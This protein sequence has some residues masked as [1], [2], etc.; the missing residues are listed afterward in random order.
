[1]STADHGRARL[2]PATALAAVVAVAFTLPGWVVLWRTFRAD[3]AVVDLVSD[4]LGPLWRT[5][6]LA[7]LVSATAAVIGTGL[8]WLLVRTDLPGR[9]L[10]RL[11][12]VLP[13]ALPSFIGAAAFIAGV[14][15]GGLL[16]DVLGWFGLTPPRRLRGL[17]ISWLV[18]TAFTYPYVLLPV[19]ARLLALRPS[20]E[21]SSRM[22][23]AGAVATFVRVTLPQL[24]SAILGGSLL[25]YLYCVSE[26]GAVQL[27]G[28]DTLTRVVFATRLV[29]RATSF[30]AASM[31]LVLAIGVVA[32][33]RAQR[34]ASGAD[35]R[36]GH[37]GALVRLGWASIPATIACAIVALVGLITPVASLAVWARRGL[38]DGRVDLGELVEPTVN[39]AT[40][41]IVTAVVAVLVVLP[42]AIT[43][44][45]ERSA[46]GTVSA[47]AVVV[48]F[49]CPVW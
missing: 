46:I 4:L 12:L 23:G 11:V 25:V 49:A 40:V 26:F 47:G 24:R 5:I 20:L 39:T 10:W 36:A 41:A 48:G 28:Y 16:H 29:D 42:V 9:R 30:G 45:R 7:T 3:I 34:G 18:L 17:G 27:L 14:A 33:E 15:P 44:T 32:L 2:T 8:A 37:Q 35:T 1:M 19:S 21:E 6:Q 31:L 43:T 22:L 38:A 13:L